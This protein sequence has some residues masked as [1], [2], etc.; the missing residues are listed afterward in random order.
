MIPIA[1]LALV[2][3]LAVGVASTY[4]ENQDRV[5]TTI[6]LVAAIVFLASVLVGTVASVAELLS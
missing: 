4:R 3:S 6:Q 5:T 1:F 2:V